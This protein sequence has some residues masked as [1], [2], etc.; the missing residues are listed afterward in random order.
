MLR[1]IPGHTMP[2]RLSEIL[3]ALHD[4]IVAS[5]RQEGAMKR[6]PIFAVTLWL[7]VSVC[8]SALDWGSDATSM[9]VCRN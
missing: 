4:L 6:M 3:S 8:Q 9:T 2:L 7:G 5:A 1:M